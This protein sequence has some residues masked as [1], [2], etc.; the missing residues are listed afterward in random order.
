MAFNAKEYLDSLEPPEFVAPDGTKYVGRILSADQFHRYRAELQSAKDNGELRW[1]QLQ[2]VMFKLTAC[3]FPHHWW[4]FRRRSVVSWLKQLPPAGQMRA[5]WD[6]MRSQGKAFGTEV[7][8]TIP[9]RA[10][11]V[12]AIAK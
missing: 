1:P 11:T 9:G 6:F 4:Q 2:R 5:V 7:P 10:E 8:E 3:M 12:I